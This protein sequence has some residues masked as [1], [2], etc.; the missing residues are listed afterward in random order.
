MN[1]PILFVPKPDGSK[2]L[3]VDYRLLN[4]ITFVSK[5]SSSPTTSKVGQ[6]LYTKK[7]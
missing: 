5:N 3:C 7:I 1:A 2:R 6:T 4:A